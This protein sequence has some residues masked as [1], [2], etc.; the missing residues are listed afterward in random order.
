MVIFR[1]LK[2]WWCFVEVKS[3]FTLHIARY[4]SSASTN[5]PKKTP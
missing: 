2:K 1:L 3:Q 5:V 4:Q